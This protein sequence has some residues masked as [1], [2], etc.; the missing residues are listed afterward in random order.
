MQTAIK[1]K[2]ITPSCRVD[3][4]SSRCF[5]NI[6]FLHTRS[7]I[8]YTICVLPFLLILHSNSLTMLPTNFNKCTFEWSQV[9]AFMLCSLHNDFPSV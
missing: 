8:I 4:F 9:F 3:V 6:S 5:S 1:K 7:H 2:N